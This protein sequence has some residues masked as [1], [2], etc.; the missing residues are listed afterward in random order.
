[1][2]ALTNQKSWMVSDTEYPFLL[3]KPSA[4]GELLPVW[5][6]LSFNPGAR[7]L[8]DYKRMG[9]F[10]QLRG[11]NGTEIEMSASSYF[12]RGG[13]V[14]ADLGVVYVEHMGFGRSRSKTRGRFE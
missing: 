5:D 3:S 13:Y 12:R 11:R 8:S 6:G 10:Q 4:R 1:M 14:M 2:V 9:S 7:R